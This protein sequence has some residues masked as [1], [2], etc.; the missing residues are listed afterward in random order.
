MLSCKKCQENKSVVPFRHLD[1]GDVLAPA[2][3]HD[4][5]DFLGLAQCLDLD[6][7]G[8]CAAAPCLGVGDLDRVA[9]RLDLGQV[10]D[11]ALGSLNS[12]DDLSAAQVLALS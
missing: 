3:L 1:R 8:Q 5:G 11:L 4:E 2:L 6:A 10:E 9:A 12:V 7:S